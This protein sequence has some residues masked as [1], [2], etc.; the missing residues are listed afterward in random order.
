MYHVEYEQLI[1]GSWQPKRRYRAC[2]GSAKA[3]A[4]E[5]VEST[6]CRFVVI[7]DMNHDI[8]ENTE[9]IVELETIA[10]SQPGSAVS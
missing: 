5:H 1:G 10:A 7:T 8:V 9:R 3:T 6:A 2:I 4:R